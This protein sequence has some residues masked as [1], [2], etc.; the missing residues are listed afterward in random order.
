MPYSSGTA[1]GGDRQDVPM[2][3]ADL[4]AQDTPTPVAP[5]AAPPQARERHRLLAERV[6]DARWRYYVL[7]DPTMSDADFDASMRELEQLEEAHPDLRTPDSPTQ[8]VG[9]AVST[10]FDAVEH[11]ERMLSLDNV[12]TRSELEAWAERVERAVGSDVEYLCELKVDGLAVNL[13]YEGGRLVG[14]ATRGDGRTGED[15]TPNVRAVTGIPHRLTG[16]D[17][18]PV[19]DMLEVRG[20]VYF[21]VEAFEQLNAGLVD[22]GRP[23]FANPRNAAAG[24]LRQKDPK[25]TA[26]RPLRLVCHGLGARTGFTPDRQSQAYDALRVWGL[27]VSDRARVL[28]TLPEVLEF[29]ERHGEQRHSVEHE[30]DGVV[31]KVDQVPLQRRLGSTSR[32]PRWAIAYKYRR[33]RSTPS[34]S[35]SGSTSVAPA[36]S[37][38]SE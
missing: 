33:R 29:I 37:P 24:S 34:C 11:R 38:P 2:S 19:P 13:T 15:I 12:F 8:Q 9:G 21:P 23:P 27:P 17:E 36:G 30:I 26:T 18:H 1:V 16:T 14:G 20:E 5:P 32:A 10:S 6:E 7:D 3:A 31:V 25:V 22:H 35:T 4:E 28:Q